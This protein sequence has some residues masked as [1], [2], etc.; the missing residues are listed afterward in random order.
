VNEHPATGQ[1]ASALPADT[2][3]SREKP[4]A[5]AEGAPESLP[6]KT[7][8]F[9]FRGNG[10]EYFKIWI[11]NVA[12]SILT[13]GIYSAWATV[14]SRR[15]FYANTWLAGEPFEYLASPLPILKGRAVAV[16]LLALYALSNMYLMGE[17]VFLIVL[18]IAAPWLIVKGLAFR[19]RMSAWR[20][21][22][23]R[24][25]GTY[26]KAVAALWP[27]L[28]I[29]ALSLG[30][31]ALL[32]KSPPQ[33]ALLLLLPYVLLLM[34]L[35]A[36]VGFRFSRFRVNY[37]AYGTTRFRFG[38]KLGG[39]VSIFMATLGVG[40]FVGMVCGIVVFPLILLG[41][42][43]AE[44]L[45]PVVTSAQIF[46]MLAFQKQATTNIYF[47]SA[48]LPGHDFRASLSFWGLAKTWLICL[49]LAVVTLGLYLPA[50]RVR[51]A[52]YMADHIAFRARDSLEEFSAAEA[53]RASALGEQVG[54]AFDVELSPF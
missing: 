47:N 30:F 39:Y 13:L 6:R 32:V 43:N 31:V 5:A 41:T 1:S 15:Y 20:N 36:W 18:P 33:L 35:A 9:E 21:V 38:A 17:I 2:A 19:H 54:Q 8:P 4:A 52:R 50:A 28:L 24:F 25:H 42:F 7:H 46:A 22:Q 40:F 49:F 44:L 11:V 14:R 26:L 51:I 23:F 10:L 48:A 45:L 37:S 29:A 16:A 34:F 53:Q 12:L 27:V 3:A